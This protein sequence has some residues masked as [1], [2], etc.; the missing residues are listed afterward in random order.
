M[1]TPAY[2]SD[3]TA[4]LFDLASAYHGRRRR[5]RDL[6]ADIHRARRNGVR[7][8]SAAFSRTVDLLDRARFEFANAQLWADLEVIEAAVAAQRGVAA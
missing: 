5:L 2:P 3:V 4:A 8:N 1:P 6:E 7:A